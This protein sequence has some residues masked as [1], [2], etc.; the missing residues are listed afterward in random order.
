[1]PIERHYAPKEL[2]ELLSCST[3]TLRKAAARGELRSVRVGADRRYPESAVRDWL[4]RS[5]ESDIGNEQRSGRVVP[6]DRRAARG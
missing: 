5:N 3:E 6:L 4:A 2:A 1:M